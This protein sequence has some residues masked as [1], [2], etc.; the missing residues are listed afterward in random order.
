MGALRAKGFCPERALT[1]AL[2]M[3]SLWMITPSGGFGLWVCAQ[4]VFNEY[5][6][7]WKG[8]S[9]HDRWTGAERRRLN[10]I[11]VRP[12]WAVLPVRRVFHG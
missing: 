4:G 1:F 6:Y 11:T 2:E 9:D 12:V 7:V 5:V 3:D 10:T 8:A